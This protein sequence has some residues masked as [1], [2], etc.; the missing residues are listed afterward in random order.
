LIDDHFSGDQVFE[1]NSGEFILIDSCFIAGKV[2]S[3]IHPTSRKV[4]KLFVPL[5][6]EISSRNLPLF[7]SEHHQLFEFSPK[8]VYSFKRSNARG[9]VKGIT[10][11]K[12]GS[13]AS[14]ATHVKQ[15]LFENGLPGTSI[16]INAKLKERLAKLEIQKADLELEALKISSSGAFNIDANSSTAKIQY[17][18]LDPTDKIL[19]ALE[20]IAKF[21][22]EK[23]V[24]PDKKLEIFPEEVL[25][26]SSFREE[27][28]KALTIEIEL[29]KMNSSWEIVR[30]SVYN[31]QVS[32]SEDLQPEFSSTLLDE[33]L[34]SQRQNLPFTGAPGTDHERTFLQTFYQRREGVL[35]SDFQITKEEARH[36]Y[37]GALVSNAAGMILAKNGAAFVT[38]RFKTLCKHFKCS[39]LTIFSANRAFLQFCRAKQFLRADDP[40]R[41]LFESSGFLH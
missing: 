8:A 39:K 16:K 37:L 7:Q 15:A 5:N 27:S 2:T 32:L 11:H 17:H 3:E 30:E 1:F 19:P 12:I 29:E 22:G 20:E 6:H 14:F 28:K 38:Q 21:R 36:A 31:S 13:K 35:K 23:L 9:R 24:L 18:I 41:A 34:A 4:E 10:T 26:D 40:V 33:I 25:K